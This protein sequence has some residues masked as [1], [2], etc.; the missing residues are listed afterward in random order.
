MSLEDILDRKKLAPKGYRAVPIDVVCEHY[1]GIPRGFA[2]TLEYFSCNYRGCFEPA[3]KK[4][5]E[6]YFCE[7]HLKEAKNG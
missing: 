4:L 3:M 7:K 6:G 2:T 5:A 1:R